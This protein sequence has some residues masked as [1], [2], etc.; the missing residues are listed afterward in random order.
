MA[1]IRASRKIERAG[2]NAL[3]TLLEE[4][5]HLVQ[6]IDGG[7]D[8]GEDLY[9]GFASDGR[10]TGHVIAI[11][12]KSGERYKRAKR[13]AIPVGGH[14]QD[15]KESRLPV[16]GVVYDRDQ[17]RLFWVN[18]TQELQQGSEARWIRVPAANE[19]TDATLAGFVSELQA[20]IDA[21]GSRVVEEGDGPAAATVRRAPRVVTRRKPI[22]GGRV[23]DV[24]GMVVMVAYLIFMAVMFMMTTVPVLQAE[25][26]DRGFAVGSPLAAILAC[27]FAGSIGTL[28][29]RSMPAR[30][31]LLFG[32]GDIC[33]NNYRVFSLRVSVH[34]G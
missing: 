16:V 12:V 21:Q 3:R 15:W 14:R 29:P 1:T 2:V 4:H 31:T 30:I 24:L 17:K 11:Q 34:G 20:F 28:F 33:L 25:G 27:L 7:A 6:E 19:L 8:H 26:E 13:Y 22:G 32:I 18:L 5:D 9:V 10:R 23:L